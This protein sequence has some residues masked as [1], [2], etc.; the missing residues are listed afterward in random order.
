MKKYM[1]IE[2]FKTGCF[3]QVYKRFG[4]NG[5]MLPAGLGYLNSWVSKDKNICFQLME[6]RDASLFD[7]WTKN[8]D[9]LVEF[10]IIP[11]E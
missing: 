4:D 6:T 3:E 2:H 1:V 8:W 5:R 10:E 11:V 9:D 7:T